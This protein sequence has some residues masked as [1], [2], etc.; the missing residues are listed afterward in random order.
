MIHTSHD[1]PTP[2]TK[3]ITHIYTHHLH[4]EPTPHT[5][6]LHN[7][8]GLFFKPGP[9]WLWTLLTPDGWASMRHARVLHDYGV[10]LVKEM[11]AQATADEIFSGASRS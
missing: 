9:G 8:P 10:R 2:H 3:H 6:T 1:E 5:K 7:Q 11:V 4:P